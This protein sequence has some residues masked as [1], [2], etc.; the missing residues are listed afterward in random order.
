MISTRK[1]TLDDLTAIVEANKSHVEEWHRWCRGGMGEKASYEDLSGWERQMHG[2]PWLHHEALER[3]WGYM[4]T[5]DIT[6]LVAESNG[7]VVG[8]LDV[9][10][11]RDRDLGIYL[12]LDVF[13]VHRGYRRR[14]AGTALLKAAESF[15][16]E[17]SLP[18]I[19]VMTEYDEAGGLTYRNNGYSRYREM[20]TM[21]SEIKDP[22]M[23]KGLTLT[24]PVKE[25]P[26]GSHH[27][28]CGWWNTPSKNWVDSFHPGEIDHHLDWHQI[29]LTLLTGTGPVHVQLKAGFPDQSESDICIWTPLKLEAEDFDKAVETAK[30]LVEPWGA[31]RLTTIVLEEDKDIFENAGFTVKSKRD[32]LLGKEI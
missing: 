9:I 7:K 26:L 2:G 10:P 16:R 31:E 23:P 21:E 22:S 13:M 27:M 19:V 30:C 5:V 25:P 1:A 15:A 20:Y 4:E 18:R 28:A 3:Y 6:S 12:F 8:H 14:G 17:R 32:P 24:N 11:T 29:L